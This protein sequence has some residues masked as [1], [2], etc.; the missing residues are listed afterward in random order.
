MAVLRSAVSTQCEDATT[1]WSRLQL[2][3]TLGVVCVEALDGP[4][5]DETLDLVLRSWQPLTGLAKRLGSTQRLMAHYEQL[6]QVVGRSNGCV[7]SSVPGS[8]FDPVVW[9][10]TIFNNQG[11]MHPLLSLAIAVTIFYALEERRP[12]LEA[13]AKQLLPARILL[14]RPDLRVPPAKDAPPQYRMRYFGCEWLV[15]GKVPKNPSSQPGLCLR[16]QEVRDE[17]CDCCFCCGAFLHPSC[18]VASDRLSD[19]NDICRVCR[20]FG[21]TEDIFQ[22]PLPKFADLRECAEHSYSAF[23]ELQAMTQLATSGL[24]AYQVGLALS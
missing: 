19:V 4:Q 8:W 12:F 3:P 24:V 13:A 16:C 5:S 15:D 18:V 20:D 10:S 1:L 2:V 21:V 14:E 17:V 9:C 6:A 22:Q 7:L 11:Q 23:I